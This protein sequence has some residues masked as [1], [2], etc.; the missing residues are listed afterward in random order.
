MAGG[1]SALAPNSGLLT[2]FTSPVTIRAKMRAVLALSLALVLIVG[3]A[4]GRV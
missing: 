4:G 3:P 2:P 1:F